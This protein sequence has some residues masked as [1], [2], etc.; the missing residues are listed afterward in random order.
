MGNKKMGRPATGKK[1]QPVRMTV[2]ALEL[3]RRFGKSKLH[4]SMSDILEKAF[5][6]WAEEKTPFPIEVKETGSLLSVHMNYQGDWY[7]IALYEKDGTEK[8]FEMGTLP[9][10][11]QVVSGVMGFEAV[12]DMQAE[13]QARVENAVVDR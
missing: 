7:Q 4:G 8:S 1:T 9:D 2:E 13:V 11:L 5:W 10:E 12:D 6:Q 3:L